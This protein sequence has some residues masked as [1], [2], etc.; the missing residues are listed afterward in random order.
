VDHPDFT[1]TPATHPEYGR[2]PYVR[3]R[4]EGARVDGKAVAW[5]QD[6]VLVHW[7]TDNGVHE[8]WVPAGDVTRISR[9]QSAWK[10]PYDRGG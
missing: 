9:D 1:K 10:D 4:I 5:T 2:E 3:T 7:A 6:A 8:A